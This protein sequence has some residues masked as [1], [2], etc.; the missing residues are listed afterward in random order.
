MRIG[1]VADAICYLPERCS[2]RRAARIAILRVA[3]WRVDAPKRASRLSPETKT[4]ESLDDL[5]VQ[6]TSV[7]VSVFVDASKADANRLQDHVGEIDELL[8]R[9]AALSTRSV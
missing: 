1:L 2:G 5:V 7:T 4:E 9:F 8:E 6:I 3:M